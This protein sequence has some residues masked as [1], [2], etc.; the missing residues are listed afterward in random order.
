M[1]AENLNTFID[2]FQ[3]FHETRIKWAI[4]DPD[5]YI[6]DESGNAI[7]IEQKLNV[8][9]SNE[10]KEAF[11]KQDENREWATMIECIRVINGD[12]PP[13]LIIKGKYI[14]K[15]FAELI[16]QSRVTLVYSDN[17]WSNDVLGLEW[18]KHFNKW[19]RRV[20][21]G[22]YRLLIFDGHGSYATFAFK[23]YAKENNIVLFY[24]SPYFI[25]RLQPLD[26]AIF[27]L[28]S[29]YYSELMNEN[30][31]YNRISISKRK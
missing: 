18:L 28:L 30:N 12:I 21:V 25:H 23:E 29:T 24:L 10:K 26:I 13:F 7:G 20:T 22:G 5:I 16:R 2:W 11:A 9:L 19:I 31:R 4:I 3:R 14:L 27:G 15:D 1:F 8:I 17:G 6:I